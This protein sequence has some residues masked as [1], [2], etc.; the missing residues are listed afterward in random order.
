MWVLEE[1]IDAPNIC[2]SAA[3]TAVDRPSE[4][5]LKVGHLFTRKRGNDRIWDN[6]RALFKQLEG[7]KDDGY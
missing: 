1:Q 2:N 3:D 7:S 5:G 6:G 4:V